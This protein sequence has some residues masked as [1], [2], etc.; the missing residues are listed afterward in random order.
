MIISF[1]TEAY[2]DLDFEYWF[3]LLGT[4]L[5]ID[6][7]F[8]LLIPL[9]LVSF[10]LN[11]I[12]IFILNKSEF[13]SRPFYIYMRIYVLNGIALSLL[14]MTSFVYITKRI[15]NFTNDYPAIFYGCYIHVILTSAIYLNC[16]FYEICI[17]FERILYFLPVRYQ[18]R[19][20]ITQIKKLCMMLFIASFLISS[21]FF[22]MA[23]PDFIE[24]KSSHTIRL[25]FTN[26]T[27]FSVSLAGQI[28]TY[29]V[30]LLR[31]VLTLVIKIA[32]NIFSVV[33][34]KKYFKNFK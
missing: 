29:I 1:I 7:L 18:T 16:N 23:F 20:K 24:L 33:L 8:I 15:F 14:I 10:G 31:D 21:P 30:Y 28:L 6:V 4:T 3:N 27:P 11:L 2:Y 22:F 26:V 17:L 25:Y 5:T 32:L 19:F 9:G 13:K 34:V 12:S